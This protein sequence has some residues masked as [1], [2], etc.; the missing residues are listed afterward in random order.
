MKKVLLNIYTCIVTYSMQLPCKILGAHI[1]IRLLIRR[2]ER[3]S[4]L[5]PKFEL[6]IEP[7]NMEMV[8]T[9][10]L[11]PENVNL[12]GVYHLAEI[13]D[14]IEEYRSE[15]PDKT[16]IGNCLVTLQ[17]WSVNQTIKTD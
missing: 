14:L 16:S 8:R 4:K 10:L 2:W 12:N 11:L 15:R 9:K 3:E 5:S 17:K 7:S 6:P 13:V 1:Q